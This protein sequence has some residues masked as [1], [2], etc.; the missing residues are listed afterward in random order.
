[1][2]LL[3]SLLWLVAALTYG[4]APLWAILF[5]LSSI[6]LFVLH[7][8]TLHYQENSFSIYPFLISLILFLVSMIASHAQYGQIRGSVGI[9]APAPRKV[10][11]QH[12]KS[13][14]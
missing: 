14:T 13:K 9:D 7:I 3:K 12:L 6:W 10:R 5:G 4:L 11:K 1:M 2:R 8:Y